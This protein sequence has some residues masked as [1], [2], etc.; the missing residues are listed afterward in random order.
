MP[1]QSRQR[2]LELHG[3]TIGVASDAGAGTRFSFEL[4]VAAAVPRAA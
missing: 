3:S 2:I 1:F 4:P